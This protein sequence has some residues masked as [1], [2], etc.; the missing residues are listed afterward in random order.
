MQQ[1]SKRGQAPPERALANVAMIKQAIHDRACLSGT[2]V[3]FRVRFA[4]HALGRD[5]NGRHVVL[6]FEYGGLTLGRA[7]WVC[8]AVHRLR[9][10]QRTGDPWRS[11]SLESRPPF[12]VTEIEAAVDGTSPLSK[13]ASLQ[14]FAQ[15]TTALTEGRLGLPRHVTPGACVVHRAP[16]G[17]L[18]PVAGR[19]SLLASRLRQQDAVAAQNELRRPRIPNP[20]PVLPGGAAGSTPVVG[21]PSTYG[22]R[23]A[24]ALAT[25]NA[26]SRSAIGRREH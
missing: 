19:G 7:H 17:S 4:P 23:P 21:P 10:L 11:A 5:E 3:E 24:S 25:L 12:D 26:A 14:E 13:P 18:R 9:G 15:K 8:F 20:P 6:A 16:F 2:H 22:P 1:Y